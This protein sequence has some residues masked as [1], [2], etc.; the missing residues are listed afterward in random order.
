M[1]QVT[2]PSGGTLTYLER[3]D[4]DKS[5]ARRR[6]YAVPQSQFRSLILHHTV[7]VWADQPRLEDEL[8]AMQH[9]RTVRPDLGNDVPYHFVLFAQRNPMDVVIAEGR[10]WERTAAHQPGKNSSTYGCAFY[11]DY[12]KDELNTGLIEGVRW[13]GT[14]IKDPRPTTGHR[15]HKA[16]ICP[17]DEI[18][19]A[20]PLLQPPFKENAMDSS[21]T[22]RLQE[23][24]A[25][26]LLSHDPQAM[27]ERAY[28]LILKRAPDKPG[29][30]HWVAFVEAGG[31]VADMVDLFK[32]SPEANR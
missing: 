19:V 14:H 26:A 2:L 25:I 27:V 12:R 28:R 15:D 8:E 7:N 10:G 6:G 3:S 23:L 1:R 30:A 9:L 24:E 29:K 22:K 4:W 13:I 20:L 5:G 32:M 16:T 18:Y 21:I 31:S 11:G 17:G